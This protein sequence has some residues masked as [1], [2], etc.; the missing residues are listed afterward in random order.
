M[1]STFGLPC[2]PARSLLSEASVCTS[3][4]S[5]AASWSARG[6]LLL[7]MRQAMLLLLFSWSVQ[8]A[9]KLANHTVVETDLCRIGG[10]CSAGHLTQLN[11]RGTPAQPA[12]F[13]AACRQCTA[14]RL[15]AQCS[16]PPAWAAHS[17]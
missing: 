16:L 10:V 2:C 1:V 17:F 12:C 5:P 7:S 4:P 11:A 14:C 8:P 9:D 13:S 15:L 6:C 3:M